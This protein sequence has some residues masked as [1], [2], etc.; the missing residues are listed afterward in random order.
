MQGACR[1]FAKSYWRASCRDHDQR[2]GVFG[3]VRFPKTIS[4]SPP[5][6][7]MWRHG[8]TSPSTM[9]GKTSPCPS[10]P[11][12]DGSFKVLEDDEVF[13]ELSRASPGVEGN[14]HSSRDHAHAHQSFCEGCGERWPSLYGASIST[15]SMQLR[16]KCANGS[17]TITQHD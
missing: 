6:H 14:L 4:R 13:L 16:E 9:Q 12:H 1:S 5:T 15:V 8:R 7:P 11:L 2:Q 10:I 3:E 17:S